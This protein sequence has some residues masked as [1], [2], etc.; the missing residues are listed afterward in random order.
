MPFR[1]LLWTVTDILMDGQR[2]FYM[3][4]NRIDS[5]PKLQVHYKV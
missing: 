2:E 5:G 1:G 4:T 3:C